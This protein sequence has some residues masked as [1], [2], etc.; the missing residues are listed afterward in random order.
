MRGLLLQNSIPVI[1]LDDFT[2][3]LAADNNGRV[4][5]VTQ[6]LP[7]PVLNG[8]YIVG[9]LDETNMT[10]V[11]LFPPPRAGIVTWNSALQL[12]N[13]RPN[14]EGGGATA[15]DP[16]KH[17]EVSLGGV[18]HHNPSTSTAIANTLTELRFDVN[19]T[20][21]KWA[22]CVGKALRITAYGRYTSAAAPGFFARTYV[23]N[24]VVGS[25]NVAA[26]SGSATWKVET[27]VGCRGDGAAGTVRGSGVFVDGANTIL[28]RVLSVG[29]NT[30][31]TL[32]IGISWQW[33]VAAA[34][35]SASLDHLLIEAVN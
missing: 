17:T 14:S 21:N 11:G 8:A 31:T 34:G 5:Y 28:N 20:L 25:Y 10:G 1:R 27:L 22:I 33:L 7:P 32:N 23:G 16:T 3:Y 6:S 15:A 12:L 35:N 13:W 18:L 2:Q 30:T 26:A 9:I 24:S 19:F 4:Q 29:V